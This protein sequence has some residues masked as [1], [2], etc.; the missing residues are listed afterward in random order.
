METV[1]DFRL[2]RRDAVIRHQSGFSTI[3]ADIAECNGRRVAKWQTTEADR[4][5]DCYIELTEADDIDYQPREGRWSIPEKR[6][7][8][9][10][11]IEGSAGLDL[12]SGRVVRFDPAAEIQSRLEATWGKNWLPIELETDRDRERRRLV[13]EFPLMASEMGLVVSEEPRLF[14][15]GRIRRHP[16]CH[17]LEPDYAEF[18]RLHSQGQW[19]AYG[20]NDDEP[21]SAGEV[22]SIGLQPPN[23]QNRHSVRTGHGPIRS[24]WRLDDEQQ[25]RV[26]PRLQWGKPVRRVAHVMVLSAL[27]A[28]ETI[29]WLSL[30]DVA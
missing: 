13:A 12:V 18:V 19:G 28:G 1:N 11:W 8:A 27:G 9:P 4:T 29:C 21:L 25:R 20:A 24:R 3:R 2:I 5:V 6:G 15:P 14:A 17:G 22:F 7:E 16:D 23:V 10:R 30:E 26:P